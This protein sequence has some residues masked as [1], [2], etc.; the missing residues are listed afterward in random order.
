M[1]ETKMNSRHKTIDFTGRHDFFIGFDSDGCVFDSM[2]LKHKECFCPAFIKHFNLQAASKYAREVWEF[3]NLYSKTRGF[4]R[5]LALKKALEL[6][7][8][9][10][11]F[12]SRGVAAPEMPAALRWIRETEKL[13]NAN[14]AK[15]AEAEDGG[16]LR[17]LLAWSVEVNQRIEDMVYGVPPF[18][19][20]KEVLTDIQN[21]ADCI[22]V[23][24]TPL[25]ALEREWKENEIDQHVAMICGQEHGTKVE[26]LH[27]CAPP[28]RY[29]RDRV[30]MVGD[31]PGD[32]TA[33]REN[34]ALFFPIIPGNEEK[35]WEKLESEALDRFFSGTYS[36]KYEQELIEE[37]DD[38][39]PSA[40]SW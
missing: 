11:V 14:L 34:G 16:D 27:L 20:V 12:A 22:V 37:F 9:R 6:I 1:K 40:P 7:A 28:E 29:K 19:K 13:D 35:M 24:Q 4:N 8:Q 31:A 38:A 17:R 25:E 18:P 26:H 5:F 2:E 21:R 10:A 3:V 39:L 23:S 30:L 15:S 32:L 36:G 33:A